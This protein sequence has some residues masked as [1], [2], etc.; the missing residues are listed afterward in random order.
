MNLCPDCSRPLPSG[1]GGFCPYCLLRGGLETSSMDTPGFD[2]V[3]TAQ[4]LKA[5][6]LETSLMGRYKL[7]SKLGEGGFGIVFKAQQKQPIQ[8]EV[9][10]KVLR[11]QVNATPIIA[12]FEAERQ[13][14]AMMDHPGIARVLDAGE[15]EDGR[16][17]FVMER[18]EGVPV[19]TY[20]RQNNPAL[21]ERLR[22]FIAICE[23]V[24]HAHQK[25]VIHRDLKPAN[26]LV[27]LDSGTPKPKVIDFGLAKAL[28]ARALGRHALYTLHDQIIGTPG[29]L[30]PEQAEHGGDAADVRGDVYALGALLY[31]MLTGVPVV[32]QKSLI[33]KP[34][35]EALRAATRQ[36]L[37][38]P[39]AKN[40]DLRGDLD[41]ITLK[42]LATDPAQRYASAES[43]AADVQRHLSEQPVSAH[44]GGKVY[45]AGKFARRHRWAVAACAA[46]LF[47]GLTLG[48]SG[49]Q[50]YRQQQR[51]SQLEKQHQTE[52]R[53]DSSRKYFQDARLLSERGRNSDAITH[54]AYAL[55]EDPQN[56]TAATYLAAL[57]AQSHL[58]HRVTSSLPVKPGWS[59]VFHVAVNSKHRVAVAVCGAEQEAR[60]D[61]IMRWKLD[62]SREQNDSSSELGLPIGMKATACVTSADDAFLIL[63]FNDGSLARYDLGSGTLSQFETKMSGS[64]RALA[65]SGEGAHVVAAAESG[66]VQ[67]W[68]VQKQP[69]AAAAHSLREPVERIAIDAEAR[70]VV[71]SHGRSL[72]AFDPRNSAPLA[73]PRPMPEGIIACIA[74]NPPGT[75]AAVGLNNGRI[76]ILRLPDLAPMGA[77]LTASAAVADLHF[78][79]DGQV[80]L[81]GDT[82]GIV[83]AWNAQQMR[84][85]D[86]GVRLSGGIRLCRIIEEQQHTLA[87]SERGDLRL[88]R[89]DGQTLGTHQSQ[90]L[91]S[92]CAISQDGTLVID[93]SAKESALEVWEVHSRMIQPMVWKDT[94]PE[95]PAHL[96]ASAT[97][98][99]GPELV[100]RGKARTFTSYLDRRVRVTETTSGLQICGDLYHD[101]AVRHLMLTPDERTLITITTEGTHRTWDVLTGLP[102]MPSFK[103]NERATRVQP[104]ADGQTCLYR[105]ENGAWMQLPVPQRIR[106]ATPWFIDFAEARAGKHLRADGASIPIR[107]ERQRELVDALPESDD[108]LTKLARWLMKRADEREAWPQ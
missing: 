107:R 73:V 9:A 82:R 4:D 74:V 48:W 24:H 43:L 30:S 45:L 28:E 21:R 11:A 22:L 47:A 1:A 27:T 68:D 88:W 97:K 70:I 61:L 5:E 89:M 38:L 63:G 13:A 106:E 37:T 104:S 35:E 10:I 94:V 41:A 16:P 39:S 56:S 81:S 96:I 29:Y 80:L 55:R 83:T 54:L 50:K 6:N 12:R 51:E 52:R 67:L 77:P 72:V 85:I 2:V 78:N 69:P 108:P 8:R 60:S 91:I 20:V 99:D 86:A 40:P 15:T 33:G 58:G 46:L 76:L 75:H 102:L 105:R 34:I 36:P 103:H 32:D 53:L 79:R 90:R 42:A 98:P 62:V 23:A 64:I 65:I 18:V 49:V 93:S 3:D 84:P 31:E 87:I 19:T 100:L 66:E 71:V 95:A 7:G 57:L 26:I 17:F 25:G 44:A 59:R 101:K 92:L 14:L